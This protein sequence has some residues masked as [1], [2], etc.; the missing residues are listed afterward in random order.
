MGP[1]ADQLTLSQRVALQGTGP[2]TVPEEANS[3]LEQA[4]M[5]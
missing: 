4:L 3:L 1:L 5:C 2:G